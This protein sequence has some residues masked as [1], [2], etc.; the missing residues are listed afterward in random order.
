MTIARP[1]QILLFVALLTAALLALP[2]RNASAQQ[3]TYYDFNTPQ[4][5]SSQYSY[6]CSL[7]AVNT[8]LFCFNYQYTS[9]YT[10]TL[11]PN[12]ISDTYPASIDPIL[13][14]NPPQSGT[15]YATQMTIPA[16][17]QAASMWFSVPQVV[18]NGF[19]TWFA[20][21]F[22]PTGKSGNTADG[23]AFVI[24]NA[25]G[26]GYD[27]FRSHGQL[28]RNLRR[29][30]RRS[31]AA[32]AAWATAAS[33]TASPSNSIPSTT[34]WDPDGHTAAHRQRQ[35][36]RPA[37]L[38]RRHVPIRP[39]HNSFLIAA[40]TL[41][42]SPPAWS[43]SGTDRHHPHLQSLTSSVVPHRQRQSRHPRRRQHPSGGDRLQRSQRRACQS[44]S[45]YLDP[46]FDPGTSPPS[47][48]AMRS[49]PAPTTSPSLNLLN[50]GSANDSAYVG[51]TSATGAAFEQHE[52]IGLDLHSPHPRPANPAHQTSP[53]NP[54]TTTFLFGTHN[55]SVTYPPNTVPAGTVM[56]VIATPFPRLLRRIIA[57][58]P[59]AGAKCQV[60]D[61]TGDNCIVYNVSCTNAGLPVACPAPS[62]APPDC[63]ADP[64]N[65]SC[66]TLTTAYDNSTQPVSAGFL[67]G[68]PFYAP[69]SSILSTGN[70]G[71]INCSGECAVTPGQTVNIVQNDG[72]LVG[73]VTVGAVTLTNQFPFTS[74]STIPPEPNGGVFLTSVNLQ[75]IYTGY[76]TETMDGSTTGRTHS[77]SDFIA[78]SMTPA[79]IGTQTQLA[80]T[81][82]PATVESIRPAYRRPSRFSTR[83]SSPQPA[84]ARG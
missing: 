58:T 72:T 66:L 7:V 17:G 34:P 15:F 23:L 20:F 36:H 75:N 3:I 31:A 22:T 55:Y 71:T 21:K 63:A 77:F 28:L 82:N 45:V 78:T 84:Q 18:A 11:S 38:R 25:A 69:V 70:A 65:P 13:T 47:P 12:F 40:H 5:N 51:F 74:T 43:A 8:P 32:A 14:D 79:F 44:L 16:G 41:R 46:A 73:Q 26:G 57:G 62:G 59:F 19:T 81:N 68:D 6:M 30:H 33:T 42:P 9:G 35:P 67:Q 60:Y 56:T 1:K 83:L 39:A 27:L 49:S 64:T 10:D 52:L 76:S 53:T 61:D 50:S 48:S 37:K 54:T 2:G 29:P 4:A 24:Q 80:A